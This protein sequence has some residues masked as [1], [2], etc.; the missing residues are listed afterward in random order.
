MKLK[1]QLIISVVPYPLPLN[2]RDISSAF[3][4]KRKAIIN[5]MLMVRK[6]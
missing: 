1:G 2:L 3:Y 6:K 4:I 5:K